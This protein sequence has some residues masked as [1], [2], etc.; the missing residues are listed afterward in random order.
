MVELAQAQGAMSQESVIVY[1]RQEPREET[2]ARVYGTFAIRYVN[3][4]GNAI[5][6]RL[7][8]PL[9]VAHEL[10]QLNPRLVHV[11][12]CA[13]LAYHI[14]RALPNVPIVFSCD[15]H[16][17]P[18]HRFPLLRPAS[19]Y[20]YRRCLAAADVIAPVSNYCRDTFAGYWGLDG[21]R[22]RI[23]PNGVDCTRFQ[24]DSGT[25]MAWRRRL[26]IE[27]KHVVLYVGRLCA[28]KGSDLLVEAYGR[29]K[30]S[31]PESALVVVGPVGQ[32]G[33]TL[34][35]PLV[36]AI[37][38]VG[39]I[40]MPP[41]ADEDLPGIYNLADIFVMPTRDLEMFGMAA[42][43]AQACGKPLIASDGGGL[44]ETV[45]HE[46]GFRFTPGDPA[47]LH[48]AL[49]RMIASPDLRRRMGKAARH[50]ALIYN[51]PAVARTADAVYGAAM[52]ANTD[53]RKARVTAPKYAL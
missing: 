2:R 28:Q 31:A 17:E 51:W 7:V 45:P 27:R 1:S 12:N 40:Y 6:R 22:C 19:R 5:S 11:H 23:I 9:L 49:A 50:N 33:S 4:E 13:E 30:T 25:G 16:R 15:Y 32:F 10:A 35:S 47:A 46:V 14:R 3:A 20:L 48:D 26:G 53:S 29:L 39:G 24:P 36:E 43:E 52:S 37:Q 34:T 38:R 41:V 21:D 44:R 42:V 18:L 8:F